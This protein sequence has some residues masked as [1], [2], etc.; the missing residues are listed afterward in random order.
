ML[1]VYVIA[2][3][4]VVEFTIEGIESTEVRP[5]DIAR[6]DLY[7]GRLFH[8]GVV[9][10]IRRNVH[11][12]FVVNTDERILVFFLGVRKSDLCSGQDIRR[13]RCKFIKESRCLE[14][15]DTAIPEESS[16]SDILLCSFQIRLFDK[17]L[18]IVAIGFNVTVTGFRTRRRNAKRDHETLLCK[19]F[20]L[21]QAFFVSFSL[22]D[23]VV[24]RRYEN[25]I[26]RIKAKASESD[27]RSRVAAYRFQKEAD[28]ISAHF[29]ELIF[30][31]EI[32]F[33]IAHDVLRTANS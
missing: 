28:I 2:I 23:H 7:L 24:R 32:L 4:V 14:A 33:C 13:I 9:N 12:V 29:F 6:H 25:D 20:S 18:D 19:F 1:C 5:T 8:H 31:Q 10:R 16:R 26:F 17:A 21:A 3:F 30:S 22:T 27:C 15:E 11:H